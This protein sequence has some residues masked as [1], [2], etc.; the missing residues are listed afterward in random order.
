[1][2]KQMTRTPQLVYRHV[3]VIHIKHATMAIHT[4]PAIEGSDHLR[5]ELQKTIAQST[6][7]VL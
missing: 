1:M 6:Y 7:R 5:E 2:T 4:T 3:R